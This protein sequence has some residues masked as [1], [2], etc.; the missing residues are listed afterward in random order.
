VRRAGVEGT[1]D[2]VK[3]AAKMG[4]KESGVRPTSLNPRGDWIGGRILTITSQK[5]KIVW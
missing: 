1:Y 2:L 4:V 3:L 5:L